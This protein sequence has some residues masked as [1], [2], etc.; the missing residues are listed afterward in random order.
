L[1]QSNS[2]NWFVTKKIQTA[3]ISISTLNSEFKK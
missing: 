1:W 2:Y 3:T